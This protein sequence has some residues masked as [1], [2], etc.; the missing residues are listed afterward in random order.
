MENLIYIIILAVIGLIIGLIFERNG[1]WVYGMFSGM[2][3]GLWVHANTKINKLQKELTTL[4]KNFHDLSKFVEKYQHIIKLDSSPPNIS[5]SKLEELPAESSAE[6]SIQKNEAVAPTTEVPEQAIPKTPLP[7]DI[8]INWLQVFFTTGNVVVKMGAVVLFFGLAFLVKYAADQNVF[9]IELRLASVGIAG[10][11]LL[12]TG[13]RLRE[14]KT[15]YALVLQGGALGTLYLTVFSSLS[16]YSLLPATLAFAILFTFAAFS[17]ALAVLQ[18]SRA[19]AVLGI[20]GGFL[21]PILTSS[22][23]GSHAGL[24]TYYLVLNLGIFGIAWFRSWRLLNVL[25]F[26]F[27][28]AVATAWG[29]TSYTPEFFASTEPFL[30]VFSLLYI[31]ISILFAFKQPVELKGYVDS[32][33]VFGVPLVG[34]GLQAGMVGHIEYA[35]TWSCLS[36]ATFYILMASIL[37]QRINKES[38]LLCEAFLAIGIMFA[39]LT[40]P[41]AFDAQWTAGAWALEGAAAVWVGSRQSRLL[42]RV[43]G[44]VL[45]FAGGIAYLLSRFDNNYYYDN[46]NN[47][48]TNRELFIMNGGYIGGAIVALSG[49]FVAWRVYLFTTHEYA[50]TTKFLRILKAEHKLA[51]P[52]LAWALVWW[53]LL[54][55]VE[56]T[57]KISSTYEPLSIILF[58]SFSVLATQRCKRKLNWTQLHLPSQ[59]L[60]PVLYTLVPIILLDRDHLF[61]DFIFLGWGFGLAVFYWVLKQHHTEKGKSFRLLHIAGFWLIILLLTIEATW[62]LDHLI[63]GAS[64]WPLA[65]SGLLPLA[66]MM[67]MYLYGQKLNWPVAQHRGLYQLSATLPI[68]GTIWLGFVLLNLFNTGNAAPLTYIPILNP[69]DITLALQLIG[70][71]YMQRFPLNIESWGN[72]RWRYTHSQT[73]LALSAFLWLNTIWLRAVH[74]LFHVPFELD[75]LMQSGLVQAGLSI[76]WGLTGLLSMICGARKFKR[77][78]W[79]AGASVMAA[80]VAKLFLFDLENTGTVARIVSFISVGSLFLVVGYFAP[81][82]PVAINK[83]SDDE[84]NNNERNNAEN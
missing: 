69:L 61:G 22:G 29:A 19:L 8:A 36:L 28:F 37:W 21:A 35:L 40:V 76:L 80:V 34:F 27:T 41:F 32:T 16:L 17:A 5:E 9:P 67:F 64:V 82:P 43:L 74:N 10:I 56:I 24:F 84:E 15:A 20:S 78:V 59:I 55:L 30:I 44:Y 72:K 58:V 73:A 7:L 54:G 65:M 6:Q 83:E 42:P 63:H 33:L 14:K 66:A 12:A 50:P 75:T 53:Y 62:Q 57:D 47:L 45:Q 52:L 23:S 51:L 39:T 13:W 31:F 77:Q 38:R 48:N 81:V 68:G 60:L 46:I 49:L 2:A 79:I 4:S 70:L 11:G 1:G 26:M 3:L 25:G 71:T 18:N